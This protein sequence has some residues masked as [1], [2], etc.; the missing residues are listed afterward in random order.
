VRV[1][2]GPCRLGTT[3]R[4][5]LRYVREAEITTDLPLW[6]NVRLLGAPPKRWYILKP[7]NRLGRLLA[8]RLEGRLYSSRISLQ[9]LGGMGDL[10]TIPLG[11]S[12]PDTLDLY[13]H[14]ALVPG[15]YAVHLSLSAETFL[16]NWTLRDLLR[17]EE[18]GDAPVAG[19]VD[20]VR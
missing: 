7:W 6:M 15:R 1:P 8:Q 2:Q 3:V 11:V 13:V 14:W 10:R 18:L 9:P 20:A 16:P 12:V 17:D 4:I 19:W 5:P